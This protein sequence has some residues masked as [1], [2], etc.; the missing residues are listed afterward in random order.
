MSGMDLMDKGF[1][2][3]E[4]SRQDLSFLVKSI[5]VKEKEPLQDGSLPAALLLVTIL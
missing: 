1:R 2:E 5:E 3:R 4:T